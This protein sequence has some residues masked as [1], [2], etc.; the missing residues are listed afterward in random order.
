MA[1]GLLRR[2]LSLAGC[3]EKNCLAAGHPLKLVL[4]VKC[5]WKSGML[6]RERSQ[7][8]VGGLISHCRAPPLV[9]GLLSN[10][11]ADIQDILRNR[12]G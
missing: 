7:L 4:L 1:D 6:C 2:L 3:R 9:T 10:L 8:E 12:K 11:H 5:I